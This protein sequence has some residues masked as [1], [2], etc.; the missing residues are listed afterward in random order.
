MHVTK[1][2]MGKDP[3]RPQGR[4]M[5]FYFKEYKIK[6]IN[7]VSDSSLRSRFKTLLLVKFDVLSEK[8]IH[9]ICDY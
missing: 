8:N 1:T 5:D 2:F 7:V 4:P 6:F 9:M 3:F